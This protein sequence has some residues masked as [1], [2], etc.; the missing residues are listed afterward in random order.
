MGKFKTLAIIV[1]IL[2][3]IIFMSSYRA[4][5]TYGIY[6]SLGGYIVALIC[7]KL[8]NKLEEGNNENIQVSNNNNSR[9]KKKMDTKA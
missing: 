7:L 1:A 2:S 9:T 3:C 4:N 8:S 5:N 6:S